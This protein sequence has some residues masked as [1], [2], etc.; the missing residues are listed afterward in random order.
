MTI[1][2]AAAIIS[3]RIIA[4]K[5]STSFLKKKKQKTSAIGGMGVVTGNAHAVIDRRP[6][7]SSRAPPHTV[8][9]S[10]AKQS[11]FTTSHPIL[12]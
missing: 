4:G 11:I 1:P 10:A 2:A 5:K 9:A 12:T 8:I 3:T 7:P 6:T